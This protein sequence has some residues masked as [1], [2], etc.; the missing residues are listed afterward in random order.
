MLFIVVIGPFIIGFVCGM[1]RERVVGL[2]LLLVGYL[3]L[4]LFRQGGGIGAPPAGTI[5]VKA[6]WFVE[7]YLLPALAGYAIAVFLVIEGILP[8]IRLSK[9]K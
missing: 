7:V 2:L 4:V 3:L 6:A 5:D 1:L 9:K 8:A